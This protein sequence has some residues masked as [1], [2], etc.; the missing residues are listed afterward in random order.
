MEHVNSDASAKT[1]KSVAE[2]GRDEVR[3][4]LAGIGLDARRFRV[5]QGG[6]AHLCAFA[7]DEAASI[8]LA[9]S[10]RAIVSIERVYAAD[11]FV[12]VAF[13]RTFLRVC[14]AE[15]LP[16]GWKG[17]DFD[18]ATL[19]IDALFAPIALERA[20]L[21]SILLRFDVHHLLEVPAEDRNADLL[22]RFLTLDDCPVQART[23][24]AQRAIVP[25]RATSHG[26]CLRRDEALLRD[27]LGLFAAAYVAL[28]S[29]NRL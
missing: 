22:W 11:G 7:G 29:L 9:M 19:P 28:G 20:R 17:D 18:P 4:A 3:R 14:L 26:L 24:L 25:L 27:R 8:A 5:P 10:D 13:A 2:R 23:H 12:N 1:R 21:R 6:Q 16:N 15:T